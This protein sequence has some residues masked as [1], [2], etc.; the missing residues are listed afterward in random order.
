MSEEIAVVKSNCYQIIYQQV[1]AFEKILNL[2]PFHGKI[3]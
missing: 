3:T 1:V 2:K